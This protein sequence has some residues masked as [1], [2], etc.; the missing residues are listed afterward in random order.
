MLKMNRFWLSTTHIRVKPRPFGVQVQ[1]QITWL[2]RHQIMVYFY[3]G[4]FFCLMIMS[5]SNAAEPSK[6]TAD[7]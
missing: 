1:I 3:Y 5:D 7:L 4:S 2:N 6:I